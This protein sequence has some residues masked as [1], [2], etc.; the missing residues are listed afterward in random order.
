MKRCV[1]EQIH[2][3]ADEK[4]MRLMPDLKRRR[5][6]ECQEML[7]S[8]PKKARFDRKRARPHGEDDRDDKRRCVRDNVNAVCT[9][10]MHML[11]ML[12]TMASCKMQSYTFPAVYSNLH[13]YIK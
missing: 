4:R 9:N 12:M 1:E 10:T 13:L 8:S 3:D 11:M 6:R 7:D 5:D 2:R